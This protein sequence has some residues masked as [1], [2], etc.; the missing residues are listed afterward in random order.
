[1]MTPPLLSPSSYRLGAYAR[2]S[3]RSQRP[4]GQIRIDGSERTLYHRTTVVDLCYDAVTIVVV[5]RT[6][7]SQRPA[8][9]SVVTTVVR[10]E[11]AVQL[12]GPALTGTESYAGRH[13]A[14]LGRSLI[15]TTARVYRSHAATQLRHVV[16]ADTHLVYLRKR[17]ERTL[18][19]L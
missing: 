6:D 18:Y 2:A 16:C 4:I 5:I 8:L 1:M 19:V 17:P 15:I 9:R 3:A 10:E 13:D 11:E 12:S 14:L 7:S